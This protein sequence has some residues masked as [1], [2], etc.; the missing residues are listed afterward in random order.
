[1]PVNVKGFPE[2]S[3]GRILHD[4][5]ETVSARITGA[6]GTDCFAH[7]LRFAGHPGRRGGGARRS[8]RGATAAAAAAGHALPYTAGRRGIPHRGLRPGGQRAAA[9]PALR[10]RLGSRG[11]RNEPPPE[12]SQYLPFGALYFW[13]HPD[14]HRLLRAEAAVV[15]ND[16][17]F[18]RARATVRSNGCSPSTTSPSRSPRPNW[19]TAGPWTAR[20]CSGGMCGRDS[21]WAIAGR[22]R[23]AIRKTCWRSICCSS[24]VTVL[25]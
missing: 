7:S 13:R 16:I 4:R 14:A 12:H 10:L 2:K 17:F 9:E 22:W 6:G 5:S 11:G 19:W 15:Y 21:A 24:R 20:N 8:R 25:R 23:P 1:M 3:P 18:S